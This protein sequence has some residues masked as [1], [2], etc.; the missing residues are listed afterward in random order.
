MKL[1]D[2]D[3]LNIDKEHI[4][5]LSDEKFADFET[6]II[7]QL[8]VD[9]SLVKREIHTFAE[10]E[11]YLKT[12]FLSEREKIFYRGE[13]V[14][15]RR[16]PLIPTI[17]RNREALF[18]SGEAIAE[19]DADFIYDYYSRGGDYISLYKKVMDKNPKD[20][21]YR[22][23]AFSQHYLDVSPFVDFT[24]SLY[25]SL[26]F[27]LK[28][29][30][31]YQDDLVLYTVKILDA[32]DY[33]ED[34]DTANGWLQDYRVYVFRQ[35]EEYIKELL[36]GRGK[37]LRQMMLQMDKEKLELLKVGNSPSAKMIAIPTNDLMRY[38]Q[39]VFL[40][41]NDFKLMFN[42]YPTKSIREDF[43]VTKWIID[44]E[45]CPQLLDMVNREAPWYSYDCLL[46]V[47][48]AF[49]KAADKVQ[50]K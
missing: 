20:N 1:F 40:L 35:R 33:T 45:I 10:F 9:F 32:Q 34:E 42:S 3:K 25:V 7:D 15:D 17:F 31:E 50:Q 5:R 36:S 16:R 47:K 28:N 22:L 38:Q 2:K 39:G 12:P 23:C 37:Q 41:L 49:A 13:R 6:Q 46:D 19:V 29:R 44:K 27:A 30:K 4:V 18:D 43:A 14:D 8:D 26:S 21:L 48:K 11:Q 24:K